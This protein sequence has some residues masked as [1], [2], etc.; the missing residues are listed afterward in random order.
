MQHKKIKV[1]DSFIVLGNNC[2]VIEMTPSNNNCKLKLQFDSG[3][4]LWATV[5]G[6][7]HDWASFCIIKKETKN[8]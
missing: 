7:F 3:E 4:I 5:D 6:K 2:K 1:N 8:D